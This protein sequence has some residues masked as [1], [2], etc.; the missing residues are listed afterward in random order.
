M[1]GYASLPD[2]PIVAVQFGMAFGV[3]Q[4]HRRETPRSK[5]WEPRR[6]QP[7]EIRWEWEDGLRGGFQGGFAPSKRQVLAEAAVQSAIGERRMLGRVLSDVRG[8]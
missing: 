4:T 3:N 5:I 2:A 6:A 7:T 8:R 1:T